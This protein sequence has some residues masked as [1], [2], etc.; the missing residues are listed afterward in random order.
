M[1]AGL[2]RKSLAM[3]ERLLGTAHPDLAMTLNNLAVL[4]EENG[5]AVK[6]AGRAYGIACKHLDAGH[7]TLVL[8]REN[9]ERLSV[10]G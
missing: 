10:G 1:A 5:E 6:L 7:P 8:I 9:L 3:K 2:F 4:N